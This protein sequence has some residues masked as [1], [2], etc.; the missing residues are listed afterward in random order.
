MTE[1]KKIPEIV[2]TIVDFFKFWQNPD[3]IDEEYL[4]IKTF[5]LRIYDVS[6]NFIFKWVISEIELK[7]VSEFTEVEVINGMLSLSLGEYNIELC[8]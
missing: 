7:E 3:G 6:M 5:Q 4:P 8:A 1:K 2:N